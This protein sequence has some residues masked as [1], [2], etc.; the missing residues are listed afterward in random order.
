MVER[1]TTGETVMAGELVAILGA[2][3]VLLSALLRE[4]SVIRKYFS[5][6]TQLEQV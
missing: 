3:L 4:L 6:T 5:L 2:L 1:I